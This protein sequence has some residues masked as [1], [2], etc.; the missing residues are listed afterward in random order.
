MKKSE[1]LE[2]PRGGESI[3]A[4]MLLSQYESRPFARKKLD[5]N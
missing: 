2:K 4:A 5:W 1:K 3:V